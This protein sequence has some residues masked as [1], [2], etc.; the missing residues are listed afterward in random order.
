MFEESSYCDPL[1]LE[2]AGECTMDF[3]TKALV[4]DIRNIAVGLTTRNDGL[5][6]G[7]LACYTIILTGSGKN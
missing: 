7:L 1:C 5:D 3:L 2:C 6:C 4:K